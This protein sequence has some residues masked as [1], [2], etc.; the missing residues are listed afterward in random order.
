MVGLRALCSFEI[1]LPY[2]SDSMPLPEGKYAL[3]PVSYMTRT[4]ILG[5]VGELLKG[6]G[7]KVEEDEVL[8]KGLKP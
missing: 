2:V 8:T 3:H 5:E 1:K 4:G 6:V 7:D